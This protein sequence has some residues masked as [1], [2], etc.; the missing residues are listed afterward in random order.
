MCLVR[1]RRSLLKRREFIAGT[2]G[3]LLPYVLGQ[4]QSPS[5]AQQS[6]WLDPSYGEVP[7]SEQQTKGLTSDA[8]SAQAKPR[9]LDSLP[10]TGLPID[11]GEFDRE[12]IGQ[13]RSA[14]I[15]GV[16]F[17]LAIG[18]Q[19]AVTRGYGY[20]SSQ[21]K[22][23]AKPTSPGYLGSITKPLCAMAGLTLVRA[24]K[25]KLDQKVLEVLPLE[26]LLKEREQRQPEIDDV[27]VRMLMNHTSGLFNFV[28]E[29]FDRGYYRQLAASGKLKLVHGDI[30]QYD[31][32]RRG[33][34]KPFVS[35]PGTEYHYSGQ[36]LQVL[37]RII[38]KLSG[39]RLD[40]YI[41]SKVL[42]PLGV[43]N[44]A[45]MSYLSPDQLG[46]IDSGQA[47]KTCTFIPSPYNKSKGLCESWGLTQPND[48]LYGTHWGQADAC[49]ASMLSSIDLLRFI[50]FCS[51][52]LGSDLVR[53]VVSPPKFRDAN[54]DLKPSG[55][56]LG[57]GVSN[58]SGHFQIGHGGA[59]GGIRAFCEYT[60]D[61]I[62]Y[63]VLAAGDQDEQ[64]RKI[65]TQVLQLGR[66]LRD[67]RRPVIG[68]KQYGFE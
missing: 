16:S 11:L 14:G 1:G 63:S 66:A 9:F 56:G 32:V 27:T 31:L 7:S 53:E 47:S 34:S 42:A 60:W 20:L 64:F 38:E 40:K 65:S 51:R 19:L 24:G 39:Q 12:I 17:A 62:Q 36:G 13:I 22:V 48:N 4:A 59:F 55:S 33:M 44:H 26:P 54:G 43:K 68:W 28:E 2:T 61:D 46:L 41:A 50:S 45:T 25:L 15:V 23:V 49:G 30:S 57:W 37:G 52:L 67:Q 58:H 3:L 10:T 29:L 5:A 18:Q 6:P 35:K 21:D 8:L